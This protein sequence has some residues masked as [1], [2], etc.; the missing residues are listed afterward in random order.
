MLRIE[1]SKSAEGTSIH[2]DRAL[3]AM[4]YLPWFAEAIA[5]KIASRWPEARL[6]VYG[7]QVHTDEG[8]THTMHTSRRS[9]RSN[10]S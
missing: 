3:Y 5:Q 8:G 4:F 9:R 6:I 10:R 1:V 7:M 2:L